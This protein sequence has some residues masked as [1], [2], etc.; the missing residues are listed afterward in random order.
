MAL[1]LQTTQQMGGRTLVDADPNDFLQTVLARAEALQIDPVTQKPRTKK[2]TGQS[3]GDTRTELEGIYKAVD[4]AY[5]TS[6]AGYNTMASTGRATPS[7]YNEAQARTEG[8]ATLDKSDA[9]SIGQAQTYANLMLTNPR[10]D[11]SVMHQDPELTLDEE[12]KL[13]EAFADQAG[14]KPEDVAVNPR[15][16]E[17]F[18]RYLGMATGRMSNDKYYAYDPRGDNLKDNDGQNYKTWTPWVTPKFVDQVTG[19]GTRIKDNPLA[20]RFRGNEEAY[21]KKQMAEGVEEDVAREAWEMA[22]NLD[23]TESLIDKAGFPEDDAT[24]IRA[25]EMAAK[26]QKTLSS[27]VRSIHRS[28]SSGSIAATTRFAE[29]ITGQR[30]DEFKGE[31]VND[32]INLFIHSYAALEEQNESAAQAF[33][34]IMM[35]AVMDHA[36]Q[37]VYR[38]EQKKSDPNAED[39]P[40]SIEN[41]TTADAVK[42]W[43]ATLMSGAA[44]QKQIGRMIL[45]NMGFGKT[46]PEQQEA[47]GAMAMDMVFK[48]F[49]KNQVEA[50]QLFRKVPHTAMING[51]KHTKIGYTFTTAGLN[52]AQNM[53]GLFEVVMPKSQRYVR[54]GILK[55]DKTAIE[56]L[57]NTRINDTDETVPFGDTEKAARDKQ[58]A[59]NTP[60]KIHDVS[61][62]FYDLLNT[63]HQQEQQEEMQTRSTS[64]TKILSVLD[65]PN[66]FNIKGNG[67]GNRGSFQSRP[68]FV[69]VTDRQGRFYHTDSPH[70]NF[71][72]VTEKTYT[73]NDGK[74]TEEAAQMM[75][76][77]DKVKD[78]QF[79]NTIDFATTNLNKV[80]YYTYKYGKNWR[81]NVDQTVGNYQHNKFARSVISA[82]VPAIYSLNKKKDVI[83]MKAGIMKRFGM[84]MKNPIEASLEYDAVIDKW[85]QLDALKETNVKEYLQGVLNIAKDEEGFASVAAILEGIKFKKALDKPNYPVYVSGFFTEIDGK[86]NGLAHASAQAGDMITGSRAL[87]FSGQDYE[88]WDKYYDEFEKIQNEPEKIRALEK[89]YDLEPGTFNNFLDAYN[90]VNSSLLKDFANIKAGK[91]TEGERVGEVVTFPGMLREGASKKFKVIMADAQNAGGLEK[92]TLALDMFGQSKFGRKFTKKPVMIFAYGAGDARHIE[93]V[94]SFVDAIMRENGAGFQQQLTDAGIDVDRD[95]I[96]PLGVMMSEAVNTNFGQI[97]E[98][99]N[100]LSAMGAESVNQ[101][102]ELFIPTMDGTLIPIGDT[103]HWLSREPGDLRKQQW[104][105]PDGNTISHL[106]VEHMRKKWDPSA[107]REIED[108]NNLGKMIMIYKAATQMAVMMTHANDNIN[109][110]TAIGEEHE[111]KLAA[112]RADPN[113]KMEGP[114]L[115][116]GNT[117]LHIFDGLLVTP[118]EAEQYANRLNNVFERM[119][120][121]PN[122]SHMHALYTALTF[123]L[124][125]N[126]EKIQDDNYLNDPI[127]EKGYRQKRN[128][129][130]EAW[131]KL[132]AHHRYRRRLKSEGQAETMEED[133]PSTWDP[134]YNEARVEGKIVRESQAFNWKTPDKTGIGGRKI[135]GTQYYFNKFF[136]GDSAFATAKKAYARNKQHYKQFFY[137]TRKLEEQIKKYKGEYNLDSMVKDSKGNPKK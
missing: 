98:F 12:A 76:F 88:L 134:R 96:E 18:G 37:N 16:Y 123:E 110:Q 67:N 6:V 54:Y 27:F 5:D 125:S 102:F 120:T 104:T 38:Y 10:F 77:S 105:L 81:L 126:G 118:K 17:A 4:D 87:I 50:D 93:E 92:F 84:D 36:L 2:E 74:S 119:N 52:L 8:D 130:D 19:V 51:V 62:Q 68:G 75:D 48:T 1:S 42:R 78:Q 80:F 114:E 13:L 30:Y 136:R 113:D 40:A 46:T 86:T 11:N 128:L 122:Q 64:T 71:P 90:K 22:G 103:E 131:E 25:S 41:E 21:V 85:M 33:S 95:F 58:Q 108:K 91:Y 82:G 35:L 97:K 112:R 47:M 60:V 73:A 137:S 24:V 32:M 135:R 56:K 63:V 111:A 100:A 79:L 107:G 59:D 39:A 3:V 69:Y 7:V 34:D 132:K 9:A 44:D 57:I 45:S 106:Q 94:R 29:K 66:F 109:M 116:Y 83:Q 133:G 115:P 20:Q 43:D 14:V 53:K 72:G 15:L 49:D 99:A 26:M 70:L 129:D 55:T 61:Q 65:G 101:G 124:D 23:T 31:S 117:A 28:P 121:D 89:K 127:Y